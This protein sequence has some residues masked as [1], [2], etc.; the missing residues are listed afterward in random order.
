MTDPTAAL[1]PR[2]A[3]RG[4]IDRVVLAILA[5]LIAVAAFDT[6]NLPAVIR[7]ALASLSGTLPFIAFAV[8]AVASLKATGAEGLVAQ[9]FRGRELRMIFVAALVGGVAPFCSCEIIPFIAA[10]LALGAP[11]SAAMALWLASPLMDPAQFAITAGAIGPDFALAKGVAAVAIGVSGGLVVKAFAA[12]PVFADPLKPGRQGGCCSARR[13][14]GDAPV[15]RFWREAGRRETF[16]TT[17]RDNALFLLKWLSLAYVIEALM[18]AYVPA[19]AIG[20]LL[21]G[22]GLWP[23]V[24]GALVGA[25]A[26]L[27][28]YAAPALVGGLLEQGMS[29]GA[30]MSFVI[31][32]GV[33]CIPA[34]IAVWAL[35]RPR[36]SAAHLALGSAGAVA[37][38]LAWAAIAG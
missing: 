25:P 10:L 35:V 33:S 11:L 34:A 7:D 28:G 38:G 36:V 32:G 15:W 20:G 13:T 9:A 5:L 22:P 24:L 12:S 37:A 30:A 26:Y 21:G 3:L 1:R 27:N 17:A 23:V 8:L 31:A 4:R 14:L 29:P 2:P 19:E 6:G 16:G 18:L